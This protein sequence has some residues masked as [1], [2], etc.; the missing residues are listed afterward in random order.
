MVFSAE[1]FASSSG[2]LQLT[3]A[4]LLVRWSCS[5]LFLMREMLWKSIKKLQFEW[6]PVFLPWGS[7]SSCCL[8]PFLSV[9]LVT[10][11]HVS[12]T[13]W[14]STANV[15]SSCLTLCFAGF[16]KSLVAV[17]YEKRCTPAAQLPA[18]ECGG[19]GSTGE[20]TISPGHERAS[21]LVWGLES[22]PFHH[23]IQSSI[24]QPIATRTN[25]VNSVPS[26]PPT[27]VEF[28]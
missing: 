3:Q 27:V 15:L 22:V 28:D 4:V 26:S 1:G 9:N 5:L 10:S 11:V 2:N 13:M 23:R 6:K 21:S 25:F 17:L 7:F 18:P 14:D 19:L 24:L 12:V 8:L 20:E 16:D